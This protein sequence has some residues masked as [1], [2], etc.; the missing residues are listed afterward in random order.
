[1]LLPH[2][3]I[4]RR[5]TF[6]FLLCINFGSSAIKTLWTVIME[7]EIIT[8]AGK[9]VELEIILLS[10]I[11]WLRKIN[12]ACFCHMQILDFNLYV[13]MCLFICVYW[14]G[15]EF[16]KLWRRS[17]ESKKRPLEE[18]KK[19]GTQVE[20]GCCRGRKGASRKN[21]RE[22]GRRRGEGG[23]AKIKYVGKCHNETHYFVCWFWKTQ[24]INQL[25]N[26]ERMSGLR[27][28]LKEEFKATCCMCREWRRC[29]F[30]S[31]VGSE[32]A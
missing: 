5:V 28:R 23:L 18:N 2:C 16:I 29:T 20:R 25:T 30:S 12:T 1:M 13:Y 11:T 32:Q 24:P 26:W 3:M 7:N 4:W 10:N 31:V 17:W 9:W 21:A 19:N 22:W 6:L 8:F 27:A 15:I 14:G